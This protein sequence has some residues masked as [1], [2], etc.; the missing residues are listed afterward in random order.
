MRSGAL[1]VP[2]AHPRFCDMELRHLP[3]VL[4]IERRCYV[5]PWSER[6]FRSELVQNA[7]AHYIVALHGRRVVGYAGMWLI[8]DEAHVTNI[9]VHPEHRR[10]GIGDGLLREL[11]ERA[12]RNGCLRMTLE[13]RAGNDAALTLYR[14]HGFEPRGIRPK[15]Y[16][17]TDEDAVIM[18][19]EEL[20]S[21]PSPRA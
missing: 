12:A 3:E 13:V 7:Y 15:Y 19:K 20:G 5:T 17:D 18:W 1:A 21:E 4:E 9:A 8:L 6:A 11:E 10:E 14:K 2:D 16:S